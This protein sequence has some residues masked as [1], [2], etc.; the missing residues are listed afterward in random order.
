ME[1]E[2][3][4]QCLSYLEAVQNKKTGIDAL[5]PIATTAIGIFIGFGINVIRDRAKDSKATKNKK[6]CITEEL[7]QIKLLLEHLFT[8]SLRIYDSSVAQEVIAG[9][10]LPSEIDT[11]FLDE[12]Y[13]G[14]A[15]RYT[16]EERECIAALTLIIK[17]INKCLEAFKEDAGNSKNFNRLGISSLNIISSTAH[18]YQTFE[19]MLRKEKKPKKLLIIELADKLKL[20]STYIEKLRA[21]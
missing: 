11:P 3:F 17:E 10:R 8:E 12:Y 2:A 18:C 4:T 14:I 6:M 5:L 15:H 9:H 13:V 20:S 1:I 21:S 7:N 16:Q 19:S